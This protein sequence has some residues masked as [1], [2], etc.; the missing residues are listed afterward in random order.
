M[1]FKGVFVA[2]GDYAWKNVR[3]YVPAAESKRSVGVC[4]C[5][6]VCAHAFTDVCTRLMCEHAYG[7]VSVL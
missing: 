4:L 7:C 5:S 3:T 2:P 1:P 6:S